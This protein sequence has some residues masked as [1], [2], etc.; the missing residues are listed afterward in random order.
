MVIISAIVKMFHNYLIS[1]ILNLFYVNLKLM[2]VII[3][4]LLFCSNDNN[5]NKHIYT[6]W[7][8]FLYLLSIYISGYDSN[9]FCDISIKSFIFS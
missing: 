1:S 4:V 6:L 7:P 5:N 8:M 9:S 3:L 2:N